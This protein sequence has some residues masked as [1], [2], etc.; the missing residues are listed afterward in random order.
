MSRP[1]GFPVRTQAHDMGHLVHKFLFCMLIYWHFHVQWWRVVRWLSY[2]VVCN[3]AWWILVFTTMVKMTVSFDNLTELCKILH[4][5]LTLAIGEIIVFLKYSIMLE[6]YI[7]K[8][9]ISYIN[10]YK[11]CE[12]TCC[13]N[14]MK[15]MLPCVF[16]DHGRTFT[17]T[18]L[19]YFWPVCRSAFL[20]SS[21]KGQ[22]MNQGFITSHF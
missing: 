7:H 16:S 19:V 15:V 2:F 18:L 3:I 12:S 21:Q 5:I 14:G 11:F 6:L 4:F 13:T 20:F 1:T 8:T 10:L 22:F 9:D 17:N